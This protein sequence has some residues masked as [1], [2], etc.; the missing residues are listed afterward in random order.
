MPLRDAA[1][2]IDDA[3]EL[4]VIH[5]DAALP[6]DAAQVD[7]ESVALLDVVVE[8]GSA[9]VVRSADSM[10]VAREVEVD[11][12]HRHDLGIAAAGS[13]ALDT[14]D[15]SEGRL[16]QAQECEF[17]PT[18]AESILAGRPRSSSCPRPQAWG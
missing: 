2:T 15:G 18:A 3:P 17:L 12:L 14:E 13:A 16:A 11:V 5:I 4:A 6:D 10:E 1:K 8:H 7:A 9:E